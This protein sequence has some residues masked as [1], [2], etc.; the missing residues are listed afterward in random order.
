MADTTHAPAQRRTG[1]AKA[2]TVR[3]DVAAGDADEQFFERLPLRPDLAELP[4]AV[5]ASAA[6]RAAQLGGF[7]GRDAQRV[8]PVAVS[9]STS[10]TPG[11]SRTGR[12]RP[13][14]RSRRRPSARR[15]AG[16]ARASEPAAATRPRWMMMTRSQV[17]STSGR[18]CVESRIVCSLAQLADELA[19]SRGSASG[20]GRRS[21]RRGS[22]PAGR[23][24]GR[25]PGRR[26]GGSPWTACR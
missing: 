18:M 26:A 17:I 11:S 7:A 23:P 12:I 19:A 21:A 6:Q 20:R 22:A 2:R 8:P 13:A 16:P 1:R 14:R 9:R 15:P 25:R 5:T 4:A 24:A 3:S 10:V